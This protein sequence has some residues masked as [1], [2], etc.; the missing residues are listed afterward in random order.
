MALVLNNRKVVA[1]LAGLV[2][3][4]AVVAFWVLRKGGGPPAVDLISLLPE[5]QKVSHW[6]E[7][8]DAPFT[9]KEVVLAGER[10]NAVF[11]PAFSRIRWKV[12]VPRRGTLEVYYG[13]RE[14]AWT[15]EGNGVVFSIGVS[16]GRTF[17]EYLREAVNPR[18]HDR[19][20]RWLSATIDLTAYEGQLVELN[21]N[22]YNGPA[23]DDSDRRN[24]FALWGAPRIVAH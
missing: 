7:P 11:A 9:V 14:D 8:G 24:D 17:E 16:D 3:V 2:V 20:R 22:I 19:D 1:A 18:E 13:L 5:A 6:N 21:F 23:R 4:V 10:H 12:Q 15:G